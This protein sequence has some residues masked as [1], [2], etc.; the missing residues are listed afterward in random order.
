MVTFQ[1]RSSNLPLSAWFYS[2]LTAIALTDPESFLVDSVALLTHSE[3]GVAPG[4]K[5]CRVEQSVLH[6]SAVDRT[7]AEQS[8]RVALGNS[9]F[10]YD[11]FLP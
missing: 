4:D 11:A 6:H 7:I 9:E 5:S 1:K 8:G 10:Q 2:A 3:R